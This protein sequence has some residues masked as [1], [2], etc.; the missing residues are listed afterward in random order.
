[1]DYTSMEIGDRIKAIREEKKLSQASFGEKLSLERSAIS[2][3]E[4]KLRNVTDRTIK[5]I[6]REFNV[7]YIFLTTGEGEMFIDSDDDFFERIDRIM[8]GEDDARKNL[9]KSLV[10][11]SDEDIAALNRILDR[12]IKFMR[13]E[14]DE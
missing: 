4:R 5:D 9:F 7:N 1:M 2:L 12:T 13:G 11:S 8:T 3:I 10:Y 6:C 14:V